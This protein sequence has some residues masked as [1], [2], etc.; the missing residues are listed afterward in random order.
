MMQYDKT[1]VKYTKGICKN[2]NH[3]QNPSVGPN[4]R[5]R[6]MPTEGHDVECEAMDV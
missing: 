6:W 5:D 4:M 1:C 3:S 2:M